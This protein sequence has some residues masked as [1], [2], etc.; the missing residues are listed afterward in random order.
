MSVRLASLLV[1]V[2]SVVARPGQ[3]DVFDEFHGV[4]STAMG[5]AH[6]GLG[7]SNDTLTLNPAGMALGKRYAIEANYGYSPVDSLTH[8][9]LSAVDSKSGPVAG[10]L[11]YTHDR[12]DPKGVDA[13]LHRAYLAA[14][15]PLGEFMAFGISMRHIRG[16]FV[17]AGSKREVALYTGDVGL[18][19]RLG[20]GIGLGLSAHNI[21]KTDLSR[22]TPLTFAGGIAWDAAPFAVA[23]DADIDGRNWHHR[24][25]TYRA[26]AEYFV[27]NVFPL[28]LGW[29]YAPFGRDDGSTGHEHILSGG[30]GWVSP[31]GMIAVAGS[32]S[33]QRRDNWKVVAT[34]GFFL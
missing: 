9:N 25:T 7:T 10:G 3:A 18:I 27:A 20:Q 14:A 26:G 32:R 24:L 19:S 33:L 17:D 31:G 29:S 8:L 22:M 13:N 21:V 34:L 1:V 12:G 15:Y 28:R 2:T 5:G 6:Q 11:G 30:A 16:T 23:V 4:R